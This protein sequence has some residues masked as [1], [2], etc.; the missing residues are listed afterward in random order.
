[1]RFII[2]KLMDDTSART[3]GSTSAQGTLTTAVFLII[4]EVVAI[5]QS[6]IISACRVEVTDA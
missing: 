2:M 4:S 1:M 5:G 6:D 3:D